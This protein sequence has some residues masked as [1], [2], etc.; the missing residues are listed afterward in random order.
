MSDGDAPGSDSTGGDGRPGGS[1]RSGELTLVFTLAAI[2]PFADPAAVFADARGWSR[3]VGIVADDSAAVATFCD[4]HGLEPDFDTG[5]ADK[6]LAMEEI[7]GTTATPRHVF[8]GTS[9]EDRRIA[10]HLGWEYRTVEEVADR[11]DWALANDEGPESLFGRVL[12]RLLG[13]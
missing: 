8:V 5:D 12:D 9:V 1:R 6:W 4:A 13:G 2:E 10:D 3:Y 11:A 7:R